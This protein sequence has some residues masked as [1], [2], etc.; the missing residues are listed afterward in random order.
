ME[1]YDVVYKNLLLDGKCV[2]IAARGGKIAFIG[3]CEEDGIDCHSLTVKAGLFDIHTHGILGHETMDNKLDELTLAYA[4]AG[5]TS[6]CPTTTTK[7]KEEMANLLLTPIKTN[8]AKFRGYHLEGPFINPK[9]CG[10][11]NPENARLPDLSEFNGYDNVALITI[12]PELDGALDYIQ[13]SKAK[14]CVGHTVADYET[15]VNASKAGAVCVTHLFNAMPGLHHRE[16]SV[17]GGAYDSGMYVQLI[18][19]GVHIH[20]SVVRMIYKL[21]GAD[22]MIIISDSIRSAGLPD[23]EYE[24]AGLKVFV[25]DGV[26]RI[27]NGALAGANAT[28][29]ECVQS[30]INMGIPE[31]DAFKMASETPAKMLGVKCGKIE[32]GYDCELL[33]LDGSKIEK[34]IIDGK[35]VE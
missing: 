15:V 8:G 12:A 23:G 30:A 19:D 33:L 18:T 5:T 32:V 14:V 20:P 27:A 1:K 25:K 26:S 10:A 3:Q 24:S 7:S 2:D 29:F 13:K 22:R 6:V 17:L 11:L 34:V 9:K 35:I 4:K 28:L 21:F 31:A 16:P